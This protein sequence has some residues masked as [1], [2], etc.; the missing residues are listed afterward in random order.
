MPINMKDIDHVA[1]LAKLS[2][3]EKSKEDFVKNFNDILAYVEKLKEVNVEGI[4]PTYHIL[5][6]K[7]GWREDQVKPSLAREKVLM[8]TWD[9]QQGYF[10]VPKVVE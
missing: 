2:F 7:N 3:D 5:P 6:I 10:K 8:N 9:E 4:K 1:N